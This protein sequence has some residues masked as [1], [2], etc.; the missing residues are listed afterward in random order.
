MDSRSLITEQSPAAS[1]YGA[2]AVDVLG[3]TLESVHSGVRTISHLGAWWEDMKRRERTYGHQATLLL[4]FVQLLVL[5]VMGTAIMIRGGQLEE[6]NFA[7]FIGWEL[8]CAGLCQA[9]FSIFGIVTE[10][11]PLLLAANVN[12]ALISARLFYQSSLVTHELLNTTAAWIGSS[13]YLVVAVAHAGCSYYAW[14]GEF[15]RFMVFSIGPDPSLHKLFRR[16]QGLCGI[17]F[18]DMQY[19]L[20]TSINF[21]FILRRDW[22]RYVVLLCTTLVAVISSGVVITAIRRERTRILLL[23]LPIYI[24][25]PVLAAAGLFAGKLVVDLTSEYAY[26]SYLLTVL[27]LMCRVF[28]AAMALWC[29]SG[30]GLGL[31]NALRH[32]KSLS[33]FTQQ[34]ILTYFRPKTVNHAARISEVI[35]THI[36]ITE[37]T[38]TSAYLD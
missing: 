15:I 5:L 6:D 2:S 11:A 25:F 35:P 30:F 21:F 38:A 17:A 1:S 22:W 24:A 28:L 26:I 13:I 23:S 19:T 33:L 16:Y 31:K 8:F 20:L 3:G 4:G 37:D 32:Q 9:T 36:D 18:L 14:G 7:M 10:D 12:M 27:M 29:R 34:T